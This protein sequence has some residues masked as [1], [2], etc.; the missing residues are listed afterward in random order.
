MIN[1]LMILDV[2]HAEKVLKIV[3]DL[4]TNKWVILHIGS[5]EIKKKT[6]GMNVK[7]QTFST[8]MFNI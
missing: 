6:C 7:F 4:V 5:L 2:E 1:F 3:P 8:Y